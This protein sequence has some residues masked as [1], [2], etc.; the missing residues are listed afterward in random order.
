[1]KP[2]HGTDSGFS[3]LEVVVALAIFGMGI[4][5]VLGLFSGGLR[6]ARVTEESTRAVIHAREKMA[7]A[8]L[9]A[10]LSEGTTAGTTDDGFKW[11]VEV[12]RPD[13]AEDYGPFNVLKVVTRVTDPGGRVDVV[14]ETFK[15]VTAS[16]RE[17]SL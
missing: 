16:R 2:F 3:L 6:S 1:M 9:R 12:S 8:L 5:I 13:F 17:G 7:V 10:E 11:S 14:L 15:A 4:L